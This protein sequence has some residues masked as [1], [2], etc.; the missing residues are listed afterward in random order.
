MNNGA[1]FGQRMFRT[2]LMTT[3]LFQATPRQIVRLRVIV[4]KLDVLTADH[5]F[6]LRQC[7]AVTLRAKCHH[8]LHKIAR[9]A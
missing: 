6:D 7:D 8:A 1:N 4:A 3:P 5:L 9:M 2:Y